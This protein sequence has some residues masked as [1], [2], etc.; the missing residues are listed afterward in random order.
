MNKQQRDKRAW[1]DPL[2][3]WII[4][5]LAIFVSEAL[6]MGILPWAIPSEAPRIVVS[7]VD[8]LLLTSVTAPILWLFLVRP[9]REVNRMRE[10]FL[11]DLFSSIEVDRRRIAHELHDGV[12]Q[13]L[14]L[15]ISGLRT[16]ALTT[17]DTELEQRCQRLKEIAYQALGDVKRLAL[18]LRPSILDDLGLAPALER[19][20]SD[21][22]EH[23]EFDVTFHLQQLSD[24][25][26]PETIETVVYRVAQEALTNAAKHAQATR[27]SVDLRQDLDSIELRIEDN[28]VGIEPARCSTATPGHLGITGMRER[29]SSVGGE[30]SIESHRPRGTQ[31]IVRIPIDNVIL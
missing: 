25:R 2:R 27:V 12:G 20:V 11:S 3:V 14:T 15:L 28:G 7:L 18:G 30:L 5:L 21:F 8:G 29:I 16:A 24:T 26:L 17:Q 22:R 6:L 13:S 31:L 23:H 4:V 19:L 1:R 10:Q 9:L